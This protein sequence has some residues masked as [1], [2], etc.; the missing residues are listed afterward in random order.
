MAV[1]LGVMVQRKSG[2]S[3]TLFESC[4]G[5]TKGHPGFVF[6]FMF[7]VLCFLWSYVGL[8]A[9]AFIQLPKMGTCRGLQPL[10]ILLGHSYDDG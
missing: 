9:Y 2:R 4:E 6:C 5:M 10:N 8:A 1:K 3:S 7:F